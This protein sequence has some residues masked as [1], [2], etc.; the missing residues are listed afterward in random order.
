MAGKTKGANILGAQ[1]ED[2]SLD[3]GSNPG[4]DPGTD[5]GLDPGFILSLSRNKCLKS[6]HKSGRKVTQSSKNR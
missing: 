3:P 2:P 1:R 6:S 5:P 4:T